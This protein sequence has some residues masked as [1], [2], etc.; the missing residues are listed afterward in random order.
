MGFTKALQLRSIDEKT[1][2]PLHRLPKFPVTILSRYVFLEIATPF[3]VSL[4][5][6]TGIL[7]LV[8]IL[9]LVDLVINKNVAIG[10]VLVLFSYVIPRFLEIA[11]PMSLLLSCII[12]FGRLSADSELIVMRSCGVSLRRLAIPAFSFALIAFFI[13]LTLSL[14]IRPLANYRLGVGLFEIAKTRASAGLLAGVFNDLGDLTIFAEKIDPSSTRLTN[15]IISDRRGEVVRNFIAKYGNIIAD[16]SART[17]SLR[18]FNGAIHE[19][20]GLNYNLTDFNVNN[21]NLSEKELLAGEASSRGKKSDEMSLVELNALRHELESLPASQSDE[22][23]QQLLSYDIEW[24]S[25]FAVPTACLIVVFLGMALGIQ[26]SRGGFGYGLTANISLGLLIIMLFYISLAL[27]SAIAE[28]N[29]LPTWLCM[30]FPNTCIGLLAVY[31]FRMV[32]SER[33]LAVTEA[34]ARGLAHL[35]T[36]QGKSLTAQAQ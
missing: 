27:S 18:L 17:L 3:L 28:K 30:W 9:K 35:R 7:F 6:F 23:R 14:W 16:D 8:R 21:L 29:A 22:Q 4:F 11:I 33:W 5:V 26:S 2:S 15:L 20:V 10:D 12:A 34:I 32:E 36:S 19:G 1:P 25:R 31:L 13:S 24:H